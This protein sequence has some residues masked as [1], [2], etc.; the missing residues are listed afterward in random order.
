MKTVRLEEIVRQKDP[1][2]KQLVE[3]LAQ[4]EVQEA[5][6]NLDRQGRVHE[7]QGH[8]ERI[9]TIAKEYAQLPENTLVISPD[10]RSRMEINERVHAEL[11]R[12]GLVS[13]EE[14][15]IRTLVPRQDLTGADR[16]WA[17]RYEVGD[18]LRYSRTSKRPASGK[19]RTHR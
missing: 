18:V 12:S 11:Q 7:I 4:G 1:A 13:R 19:A 16:T 5:I 8:D 15:R 6:Q 17:A 10:N 14:R 2:L 3:Q 9:A